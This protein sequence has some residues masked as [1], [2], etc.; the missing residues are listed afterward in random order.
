MAGKPILLRD[1]TGDIWE[2][3][4]EGLRSIVVDGKER[5]GPLIDTEDTFEIESRYG[6]LV[7]VES[8]GMWLSR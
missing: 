5:R 8:L 7:P 6:P 2:Q 1:T 3:T 4:A